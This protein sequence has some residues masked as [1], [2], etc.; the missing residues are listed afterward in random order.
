[1][2][3]PVLLNEYRNQNEQRNYPFAD[4]ATMVD[5]QGAVLP[6]DFIVDAILY[7]IGALGQVYLSKVD[8]AAKQLWFSDAVLG[9]YVGYATYVPGQTYAYV[10]QYQTATQLFDGAVLYDRQIGTVVFGSSAGSILAG[11]AVREFAADSTP[12][13][14]TAFVCIK[15]PGV[16][17]L[18]ETANRL[19]TG[20]VTVKGGYGVTTWTYVD[21]DGL[22]ILEID[23]LGVTLPDD[24]ECDLPPPI[25]QLCITHMVGAI[26]DV[27][28]Y[29]VNTIALNGHGFCLDE[30]CA[31]KKS[32][33]LPDATGKLPASGDDVCLPPPVPPVP[34]PD[35]EHIECVVP[36][37]GQSIQIVAPSVVGCGNPVCIKAV[38]DPIVVPPPRF[39]SAVALGVDPLKLMLKDGNAPFASRGLQI[40]LKGLRV[41]QGVVGL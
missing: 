15:Q 23:V 36:A 30:L 14:P 7:P 10:H 41:A 33:Q 21:G 27:G 29:A 12:L 6:A 11:A 4:D 38:S 26:I 8:G 18:I 34:P 35:V 5:N 32:T 19:L 2:S 3:T 16:T 22:S 9:I 25:T 13:V 20:D 40:G 28:P 24:T 37:D 31:A 39:G 17:G 1:M